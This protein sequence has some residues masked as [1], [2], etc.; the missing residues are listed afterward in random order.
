MAQSAA[1]PSR[2]A[3][4]GEAERLYADRA[5]L[6][7]A[8]RAAQIWSAAFAA[9]PANFDLAWKV[10]RVAYWLGGHGPD[11]ERRAHLEAGLNAAEKAVALQPN[12]PEGHFWLAG[13][14]A[15][16]AE[17]YGLRQG[18]KYRKPIR[19]ELEVTLRLDPAFM[20]GSADRALGRWYARVPRLAGGDRK[21]AESHL[22][23]SLTYNQAST[24][25]HFFLGEFLADEGRKDE[26]RAEYQKVLDA[27]LSTLWA[28]EDQEFKEKA[29]K[30]LTTLR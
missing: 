23:T 30:A 14:M 12:K 1:V 25:S 15:A 20:E 27:P 29:R 16:L 9:D 19:D 26:A 21:L 18:L 10:A 28:P 17:S 4:G 8:Q 24:I 13:N 7:S 22:R 6:A 3:R 5:T 2:E 11:P